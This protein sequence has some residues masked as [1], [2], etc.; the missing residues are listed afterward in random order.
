VAEIERIYRQMDADPLQAYPSTADIQVPATAMASSSYTEFT[1]ELVATQASSAKLLRITFADNLDIL[2]T[3]TLLPRLLDVARRRVHFHIQNNPNLY[4]YVLFE[5]RKIPQF[6]HV[7]DQQRLYSYLE[8]RQETPPLFWVYLGLAVARSRNEDLLEPKYRPGRMALFESAY[9]LNVYWQHQHQAEQERKQSEAD[10]AAVVAWIERGHRG[11]TVEEVSDFHDETG[12]PLKDRHPDTRAFVE[13][14][15]ERQRAE[16]EA[17]GRIPPIVLFGELWMAKGMVVPL[18]AGEIRAASEFCRRA[19]DTE[20]KSKMEQGEVED[21]A[22]VDDEAF[23]AALRAMAEARCPKLVSMLRKPRLVHA[24]LTEA[25][26]ADPASFKTHGTLFQ[27]LDDPSYRRMDLLLGLDREQ[28]ITRIVSGLSLIRRF[29]L[30]R[31][32]RLKR[33]DQRARTGPA[34]EDARASTAPARD[35]TSGPGAQTVKITRPKKGKPQTITVERPS[36]KKKGPKTMDEA[37]D[38]LKQAMSKRKP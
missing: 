19:I 1:A 5:L 7:V 31:R 11:F 18:L 32:F 22:I 34:G 6:R 21:S 28:I 16:A 23:G 35:E 26:E 27:G 33:T 37:M 2:V 25:A 8:N 36:R 17:A 14:L 3:A 20:W 12:K 15:L 10:R 38:K 24:I 29:L 13:D 9:L 30:R 4:N